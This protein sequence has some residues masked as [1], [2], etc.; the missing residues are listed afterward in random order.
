MSITTWNYEK[1]QHKQRLKKEEPR[2]CPFNTS[3]RNL[4]D[5]LYASLFSFHTRINF[6][7]FLFFLTSSMA[8]SFYVDTKIRM[9]DSLSA[10]RPLHHPFCLLM[11]PSNIVKQSKRP[12][13]VVCKGVK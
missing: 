1:V 2:D 4:T 3:A 7:L 6:F 10:A 13:S 12:S 9:D 5:I 8:S 11:T